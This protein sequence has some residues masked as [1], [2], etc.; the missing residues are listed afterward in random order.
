MRHPQWNSFQKSLEHVDA[1]KQS[2]GNIR[3]GAAYLHA[4]VFKEMRSACRLLNIPFGE[5]GDSTK[6]VGIYGFTQQDVAEFFGYKASSMQNIKSEFIL[7]TTIFEMLSSRTQDYNR[8]TDV[9][10]E[11]RDTLAVILTD[12]HLHFHSRSTMNSK[13]LRA[14]D[15]SGAT[16]KMWGR[17]LNA[18]QSLKWP[19]L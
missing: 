11:I 19:V 14:W 10:E 2:M 3:S 5:R 8:P 1:L 7:A 15:L 4:V 9:E 17:N 16:I 6:A 12:N 13:Q 18:G